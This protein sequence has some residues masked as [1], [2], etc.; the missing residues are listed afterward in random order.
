MSRITID[1]EDP[2]I[3]AILGLMCFTTGPIAHTLRAGGQEIPTKI[4][5]EQTAVFIWLIRVYQEHGSEWRARA[6]E[7]LR[8]MTNDAAPNEHPEKITARDGL[9]WR[10]GKSIPLPDADDIARRFGFQ[11]AEQ[12]VRYL[13]KG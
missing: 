2:E 13:A 8:R 1:T 3:R 6:D 7:L 5:A 12:F 10:D 11:H 9:L 4:E